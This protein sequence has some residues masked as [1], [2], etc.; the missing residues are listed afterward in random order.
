[1]RNVVFMEQIET[2]GDLDN[3]VKLAALCNFWVRLDKT[4][5]ISIRHPIHNCEI[6]PKFIGLDKSRMPRKYIVDSLFVE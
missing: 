3:P 6:G 1:M 2:L 5:K 4:S